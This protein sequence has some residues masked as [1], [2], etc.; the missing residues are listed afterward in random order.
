MM[1][2]QVFDKMGP[3]NT[4]LLYATGNPIRL[5]GTGTEF[6]FK[7][8]ILSGDFKGDVEVITLFGDMQ[9]RQG[10]GLV[11]HWESRVEGDLHYR[12]DFDDPIRLQRLSK[13]LAA[14][15]GE[16]IDFIGNRH[17]NSFNGDAAS[18][19]L[20]GGGGDDALRGLGGRDVLVGGGGD[21]LLSGGGGNDV[22]RG[23]GG[24]DGLVG[25]DGRDKLIGGGGRDLLIGGEG[26]DRLTGGGGGDRFRFE[27]ERDS[28]VGRK[29]RDTITD[30][31]SGTDLIDLSEIDAKSGSAKDNKFTYIGDH[32]FSGEQGELRLHNSTL[33]ADTDGDRHA[34]M[35]IFLAHHI[36]VLV[37]ALIL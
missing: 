1:R 8:K 30:F 14:A 26:P 22:V 18:D 20:K 17:A 34:D 29:H 19:K 33:S 27:S 7:W 10:T 35:E 15:P 4:S 36:D 6:S 23:G 5:T 11:E 25:G 24:N 32:K 28:G 37:D 21:D 3:T 31:V 16:G 2:V 9:P 12:I 13:D